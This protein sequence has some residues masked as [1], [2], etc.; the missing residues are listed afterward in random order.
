MKN[1]PKERAGKSRQSQSQTTSSSATA[2]N[3]SSSGKRR[4][5]KD[6]DVSEDDVDIYD[7]ACREIRVGLNAYAVAIV[8]LRQFHLFYPAYQSS[9]AAGTSTRGSSS[10]NRTV[11]ASRTQNSQSIGTGSVDGQSN[12]GSLGEESEAYARS[13]NIKRARQTYAVTDSTMPSRTPQVLFIPTRRKSDPVRSKYA[14]N[15]DHSDSAG[16]RIDEVSPISLGTSL[17]EAN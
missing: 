1:R 8:D 10:A 9:S 7:E 11:T 16:N 17:D 2:S 4:S 15:L 13:S 3:D 12:Q 5:G 6:G 14:R